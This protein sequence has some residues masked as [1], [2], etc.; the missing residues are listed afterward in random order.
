MLVLTRKK[1][2]LIQIGNDIVIKV[3]RTGPGSVKLGIDAPKDVRVVRGELDELL[4]QKYTDSE[5]SDAEAT[6]E[7]VAVSSPKSRGD[8]KDDEESVTAANPA[9][10]SKSKSVACSV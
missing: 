10:V 4:V 5:T 8:R 7:E 3:I 9:K 2:Q 1:S 6:P